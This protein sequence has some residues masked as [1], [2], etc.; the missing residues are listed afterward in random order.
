L[1]NYYL[2]LILFSSLT[3][4]NFEIKKAEVKYYGSHYLHNWVGIS[5][6]LSGTIFFDK[7]S[8]NQSVNLQVPLVSFN[9]KNSSRDSN[10]LTYSEAYKFPKVSFNSHLIKNKND[11][12]YVEGTLKF[13]GVSKKINTIVKID[14]SNGFKA[15]GK[16]SIKL[17][18]YK[19]DRP[20]LL[21][22]KIND[23]VQIEYLIFIDNK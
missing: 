8:Q 21:F 13:H 3:A 22:V 10:M 20:S 17:S 16:F 4:Q 15:S 23:L 5:N 9:S 7:T 14:T 2:L 19:I 6:K 11:S 18:D 12:L 1:K